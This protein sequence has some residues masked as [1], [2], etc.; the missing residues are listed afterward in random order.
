MLSSG[1]YFI[2]RKAGY[3]NLEGEG[4]FDKMNNL[5]VLSFLFLILI[6]CSEN[7]DQENVLPPIHQRPHVQLLDTISGY[8]LNSFTGDSINP[9]FY[10]SSSD[11]VRTGH[12]I[13][14]SLKSIEPKS[15]KEHPPKSVTSSEL[16]G[17]KSFGELNRTVAPNGKT[18]TLNYATDSIHTQIK[19]SKGKPIPLGVPIKVRSRNVKVTHSHAID[20]RAPS[21][22]DKANTSIHYIDAEHG[23]ISSFI[24]CME[25][26]KDGAIWLGSQGSGFCRYD[27]KTFEQFSIENGLPDVVVM[28]LLED[29]KGNLWIGTRYGGLVK[30]DGHHFTIWDMEGGLS[31][32]YIH[33]I[34]EDQEGQI[35]VATLG[36]GLIKYDGAFFTHYLAA[37]SED[38][39]KVLSVL[40]DRSGN[41]WL[42]TGDGAVKYDGE[43]FVCFGKN[44]ALK[45]AAVHNFAIGENGKMV[46]ATRFDLWEYDGNQFALLKDQEGLPAG[47]YNSTMGRDGS[48]WTGFDALRLI[49]NGKIVTYGSDDGFSSSGLSSIETD[50]AGRIWMCTY[51]SGVYIFN[52]YGATLY[53]EENGYSNSVTTAIEKDFDGN[54]WFG[55]TTGELIKRRGQ[56]FIRYGGSSMVPSVI[57]SLLPDSNGIWIGTYSL[58]LQFFDGEKLIDKN[59]DLGFDFGFVTDLMRDSRNRLWILTDQNKAFVKDGINLFQLD[60]IPGVSLQHMAEDKEGA[61]WIATYGKGLYKYHQKKLIIYS[62]KEGLAH[63]SLKSIHCSNDGTVWVATNN[64]GLN[65]IVGDSIWHFST[66]QGLS[67]DLLWSIAEDQKERI[68]IATEK[69]VSVLSP[70]NKGFDI[71][72]YGR[73]DGLKTLD[74]VSNSVSLDN[75]EQFWWGTGKVLTAMNGSQ[76]ADSHS[77]PQVAIRNLTVNGKFVDFRG[78]LDPDIVDSDTI[79]A[80]PFTNLPK[81]PRFSPEVN[82]LAFSFSGI[83]WNQ[84]EKIKFSFMLKGIGNSWS[85]PQSEPSAVFRN[86]SHG[87]YTFLLRAANENENWSE[88]AS[89]AFSI[90]PYWWNSLLAKVLYIV[91]I[92]SAIYLVFRLQLS[93]KL[94]V[95][96]AARFEELNTLKTNFFTN[97]SHEFRTPLTIVKGSVPLLRR[98][99]DTRSKSNFD[100]QLHMLEKNGDQLLQLINEI[101]DLSSLEEGRRTW[102]KQPILLSNITRQIVILFH[103]LAEQKGIDLTFHSSGDHLVIDA[104][105]KALNHILQNLIGNAIKYSGKGTVAVKCNVNNGQAI[106]EVS[107][108]GKGIT[109]EDLPRIF[110]RF[111]TTSENKNRTNS[112]GI[113]L[114]LTKELVMAMDGE[115]AAK[116]DSNKGSVFTVRFPLSNASPSEAAKLHTDQNLI[117]DSDPGEELD[118]HASSDKPLVLIVDDHADIRRLI[119]DTMR[120]EYSIITAKNGSEG[121]ARAQEEV[122]DFIIVDWMMPGMT[123]PDMVSQLKNDKSTSHIPMMLLTA[124]ADKASRL[125]GLEKGADAFLEKPFESAELQSQVKSLIT[126]RNALREYINNEDKRDKAIERFDPEKEFIEITEKAILE[127]L[128]DPEL[129]G[130]ALAGVHFLSRS[131]FSRKLKAI[132]GK[133]ITAFIRAIRIDV[134]KKY[135]AEGK[136]QIAEIAYEVGFSDPAYFTRVFSK[137]TGMSPTEFGEKGNG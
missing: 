43:E 24:Q 55:T 91:I 126:S 73:Q 130:A 1:K 106:V 70:N 114:A 134:A 96:D 46:M 37:D 86:L 90:A 41:I 33:D 137:E 8:D 95:Q 25:E 38:A 57:T 29:R 122:P 13:P 6:G 74:F 80:V 75:E 118:D 22:R 30:Y 92:A 120:S 68:W 14:V 101:L 28:A 123:G 131:Q 117:V 104:D 129:S 115:I 49:D 103:S 47:N 44:S 110:D 124:K 3:I 76:N 111:Y 26:S 36:G 125:E 59:I 64:H 112:T 5:R 60:G 53:N 113:G 107:D 45:G 51:G 87:D 79:S 109:P 102:T 48:L 10:V 105:E 85:P 133:S 15:A 11:T 89:Y 108:S 35:W 42:G 61:I 88:P 54:M 65:R 98:F 135:I 119:A 19:D 32:N 78:S 82:E 84:S 18:D 132:T 127:N 31:T 7:R 136:L 66:R 39:L 23:L 99:Y 63:N 67:S 50:A 27:G 72:T 52:P 4:I 100:D 34:T 20:A 93:R 128:S 69:G 16:P 121:I 2:D 56:K 116:S 40:E 58:G 17:G 77:S 12:R 9:M 83:D 97:V 21:M 94:A 81:N 71:R 62:E